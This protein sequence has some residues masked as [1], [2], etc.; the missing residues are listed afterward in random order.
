MNVYPIH[1]KFQ[2]IGSRGEDFVQSITAAVSSVVGAIP[3]ED[4]K[5][6]NSRNNNYISVNVGPVWVN[7][8]EDLQAVYKALKSDK[9]A[10]WIL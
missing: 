2:A 3:A 5:T 4:V 9:R 1:R 8:R 10:R 7:S 6:R